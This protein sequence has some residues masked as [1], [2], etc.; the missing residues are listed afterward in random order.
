[1]HICTHMC[2]NHQLIGERYF[3][4]LFFLNRFQTTRYYYPVDIIAN[5]FA[6]YVF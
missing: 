3:L 2:Y 1:M 4:L 5:T 6:V